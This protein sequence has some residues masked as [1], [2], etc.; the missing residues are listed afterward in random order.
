MA[1]KKILVLGGTGP[2]GICLLRELVHRKE[3]SIVFARTP[4]KIPDEL[5]NNPLLEV[6]A[7]FMLLCH[8]SADQI[9][10]KKPRSCRAASMT[11]TSSPP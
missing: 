3:P 11:L 1:G 6:N 10:L 9:S 4:S 8:I 2:A 7:L 5:L